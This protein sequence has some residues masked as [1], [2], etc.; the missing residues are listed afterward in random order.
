MIF[1]KAS[2]FAADEFLSGL[3]LYSKS[4]VNLI[5]CHLRGL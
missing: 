5:D 4:S 2:G 1:S 3:Y